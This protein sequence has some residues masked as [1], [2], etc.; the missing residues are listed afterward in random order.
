MEIPHAT[1]PGSDDPFGIKPPALAVGYDRPLSMLEQFLSGEQSG[2]R[3]TFMLPFEPGFFRDLGVAL[4]G[5][6][7]IVTLRPQITEF[8][9]PGPREA[10]LGRMAGIGIPLVAAILTPGPADDLALSAGT[11]GR[12]VARGAPR[13]TSGS[14]VTE[15]AIREAMK[16]APLTSQ[17]ARGISLPRVQQYVDRLLAGETAPAIK[18][19]G[20]ML[21]DGNH[22]YIAGRILGQEPAVQP[23]LGG[24][25]SSAIPWDKL[26]I[27]LEAW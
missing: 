25:P 18:V 11:A 20:K 24:R 16:D 9:P 1:G 26:P 10:A 6:L 22:R 15:Q 17:Q 7:Q 19:D 14:Q 23:W 2:G 12:S 5:D 13:I 3:T 4:A 21:V 8:L 27:N